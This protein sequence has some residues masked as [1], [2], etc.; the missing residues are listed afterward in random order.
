[1]TAPVLTP[2]LE[3]LQKTED[4]DLSVIVPIKDEEDSILI[5][6]SEIEQV[7]E[8]S[9][10]EWECL[11]IDDGSADCSLEVLKNLCACNPYHRYIELDRN[12]GQSASLAVGFRNGRGRV[13]ATL[14]GDLQNDPNDIPKLL[15][16]LENQ[17]VHMVN[18]IRTTRRDT[19]MRKLSSRIGNGFRNWMTGESVTDVGCSL[20]VF[21]RECTDN[22]PLFRGMH[23]FLPTL[24]RVRGYR[25]CE[26]PVAHR[27]RSYGQTK[28]GIGNRLWVGLGDTLFVLWFQKRRVEP[29]IRSQLDIQETIQ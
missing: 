13:I 25:I 8:P 27:E 12:Y 11:W 18:G 3:D 4:L 2:V 5:L 24:I 14:D 17:D 26:I 29:A 19:V 22:L 16:V 21:Y 6:A 20:R 9:P 7:F 10:L 15:R 28:Y 1:M 23:R